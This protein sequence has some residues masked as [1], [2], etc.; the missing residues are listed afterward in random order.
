[1]QDRIFSDNDVHSWVNQQPDSD[2]LNW[3]QAGTT[4]TANQIANPINGQVTA[5]LAR[6]NCTIL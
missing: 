3:V 6:E 1:M 5:D 2:S 4:T